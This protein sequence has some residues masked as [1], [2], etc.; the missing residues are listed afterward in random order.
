M[1]GAIFTEKQYTTLPQI[2][3]GLDFADRFNTIYTP[4]YSVAHSFLVACAESNATAPIKSFETAVEMLN[5]G[6]SAA[7]IHA[8]LFKVLRFKALLPKNVP[9][10][11]PLPPKPEFAMPAPPKQQQSMLQKRLA[12]KDPLTPVSP[13]K[14]QKQSIINF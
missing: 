1:I 12:Q 2:E 9:K 5:E 13:F 8:V 3:K 7:V 6:Q 10:A 11:L 14:K 4:D